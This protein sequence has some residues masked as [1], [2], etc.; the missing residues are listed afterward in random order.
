[1]TVDLPMPPFCVANATKISLLI[2]P[3]IL[4]VEEWLEG[5]DYF[6]VEVTVSPDV[7]K[8]HFVFAQPVD[9]VLRV[10]AVHDGDIV[11]FHV[12]QAFSLRPAE[13]GTPSPEVTGSF[14][15]VPKQ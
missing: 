2:V 9:A 8:P 13:A 15:R 10:V 3:F 4:I 5:K 12:V 6:L 7:D 1:M 11:A 14:C